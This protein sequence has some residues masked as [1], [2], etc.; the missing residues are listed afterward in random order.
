MAKAGATP[1][2]PDQVEVHK[3]GVGAVFKQVEVMRKRGD[4]HRVRHNDSP[5]PHALLEPVDVGQRG[6]H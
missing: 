4:G 5:D 1:C 6:A 2:I 3:L